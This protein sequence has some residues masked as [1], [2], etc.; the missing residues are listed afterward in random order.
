MTTEECPL[1]GANLRGEPIPEESL[2]K[3]Y[4]GE[5]DGTPQY[6]S[7]MIGV[8]VPWVYDGILYWSCP[9][10]NGRWHRWPEMHPL[11]VR[12]EPFVSAGAVP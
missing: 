2:R 3:G 9:D 7:R 1:C 10:C 6:F 8:E 12:A 11:R 4:Y 5:W